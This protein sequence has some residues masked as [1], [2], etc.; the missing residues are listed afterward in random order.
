MKNR[1]QLIYQT[2]LLYYKEQKNQS[3]IA[4]QLQ[5]SRPTVAQLL[6]EALQQGIVQIT[7]S[8]KANPNIELSQRLTEKY[9]LQTVIITP[10]KSSEHHTKVA[11]GAAVAEFVEQYAHSLSSIGIGWGSTLYEFVQ[12]AKNMPYPHLN[13][14]PLMGGANVELLHLHSNHLCFRLAEKYSAT[15]S[16]YYAP[17]IADHPLLKKEL[18]RSSLIKDAHKKA[19]AVDLAI[20][21]IGNPRESSTYQQL[22]VVTPEDEADIIEKQVVGDALASFYDKEG[23]ILETSLTK[24]M[25]GITLDELE[26]MNEVAIIASDLIKAPSLFALLRKGCVDHLI[27]DESIAHYLAEQ[28]Y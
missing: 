27:I 1:H 16:Y 23:T 24:R 15:A 18:M 2:A 11:L 22:G 5:L 26:M 8:P 3:E 4:K 7:I 6:K 25:V 12:A 13:I 14:V 21:S 9:N 17:A 10:T 28:D 19:L 20:V